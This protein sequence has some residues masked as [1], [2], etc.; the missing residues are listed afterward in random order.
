M[1]WTVILTGRAYKQLKKL[2]TTIQDLA[3]AAIHDLEAA[4][5]K[6]MGWDVRKRRKRSSPPPS[7]PGPRRRSTIAKPPA[8]SRWAG[9]CARPAM[10]STGCG[11]PTGIACATGSWAGNFRLKCF[12]WDTGRMHTDEPRRQNPPPAG[13]CAH[14]TV[15]QD[16]RHAPEARDP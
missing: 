13:R 3:D 14:C 5:P 6:P 10:T 1:T 16:Q 9:T 11:S 7:R 4:G 12:T 8:R 2:P 15:E